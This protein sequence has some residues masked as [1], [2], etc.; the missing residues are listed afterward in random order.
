M[1][2]GFGMC[3]KFLKTSTTQNAHC[4]PW[5]DDTGIC[6]WFVNIL[7]PVSLNPTLACQVRA[8]V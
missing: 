5:R 2:Q 8:R 6:S 3:V 4:L 1:A 7:V